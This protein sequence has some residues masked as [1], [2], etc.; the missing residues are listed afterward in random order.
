MEDS[1]G[2]PVG[3]AMSFHPKFLSSLY[4][5]R[6]HST[7]LSSLRK[8]FN[9]TGFVFPVSFLIRTYCENSFLFLRNSRV[10]F[11]CLWLVE[12]SEVQIW[13]KGKCSRH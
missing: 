9:I 5:G 7:V 6:Q 10:R 2:F 11:V 1:S 13:E 8:F 12:K 3:K 4:L